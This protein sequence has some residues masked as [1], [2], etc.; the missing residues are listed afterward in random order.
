MFGVKGLKTLIHISLKKIDDRFDDC[1]ERRSEIERKLSFAYD[2][3]QA[4]E[5]K[6][7]VY[8]EALEK[9]KKRKPRKKDEK[10]K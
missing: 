8:E 1:D 5:D 9:G 3:L 7:S 4:L 6:M 10:S 2:R